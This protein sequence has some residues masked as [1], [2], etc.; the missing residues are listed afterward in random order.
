MT[1]KVADLTQ[2]LALAA[3]VLSLELKLPLADSVILA[4]AQLYE[5][6]LWTQDEHFKG[7][8]GIKYI[9]KKIAT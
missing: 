5:A 4:T 7:F 8:D 3:A 1:S 9:E 6:T 2:E